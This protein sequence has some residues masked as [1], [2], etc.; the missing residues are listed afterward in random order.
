MLQALPMHPRFT[1]TTRLLNKSTPFGSDIKTRGFTAQKYRFGFNNQ[2]KDGELGETY[3]FEYR[4]HDARL[5]R[6]LSV[7]PLVL[8]YSWNSPYCFAEN[9][10]I[11]GRDLEGKEWDFS[12][13]GD[14]SGNIHIKITTTFTIVDKSKAFEMRHRRKLER[15]MKDQ[16]KTM[17]NCASHSNE[18]G[19]IVTFSSE[20]IIQYSKEATENDYG[21]VLVDGKRGFGIKGIA[22]TNPESNSQKGFGSVIAAEGKEISK[23]KYRNLKLRAFENIAHDIFHEGLHPIIDKHPVDYNQ[24]YEDVSLIWDG[25]EK[26]YLTQQGADI[27]LIIKNIMM[28]TDQKVEG[29]KISEWESSTKERN[30]VSPEQAKGIIEKIKLDKETTAK[31]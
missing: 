11:D 20:L 3:A 29:K 15:Y 26:T 2:E 25:I 17:F 4:I 31:P 1:I 24:P 22:S 14:A 16:F 30:K 27:D 21:I 10:V 6:F 5:G 18:N 7:D 9:R 28:Y 19:K 8:E 23:G 13:V 12:T